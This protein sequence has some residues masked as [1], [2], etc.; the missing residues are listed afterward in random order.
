MTRHDYLDRALVDWIAEQDRHRAGY[1]DE[2]LSA[3]RATRQRP[4]WSFPG[5]WLP[6]ELTM[7]RVI[8]PRPV[9]YLI[10]LA[11]A[12]L[13][14]AIALVVGAMPRRVAPPFGLA[15]N[16]LVAYTTA[17]GDIATV[18]PVS[19]GTKV[20]VSS[21]ERESL[22]IFSRDGSRLAF[23]REVDG[24]VALFALDSR[25]G[26]PTRLTANPVDD[27]AQ[28]A[29]SPDGS[30]LAFVSD[31]RIWLVSTDK[32]SPEKPLDLG[33]AT[34]A[35]HPV[36][37]PS[38]AAQIVFRGH[39]DA[40]YSLMLADAGGSNTRRISEVIADDPNAYVFPVITPN[41]DRL[42]TQVDRGV[43]VFDLDPSSG[44]ATNPRFA[45]ALGA[46]S[47]TFS[48]RISP[49]GTRVAFALVV[50]DNALPRIAV[51]RLDDVSS[52][53]VTGP[54]LPNSSFGFDWS[55]DGTAILFWRTTTDQV[56]IL[57]P[58]GGPARPAPWNEAKDPNWQ[59]AAP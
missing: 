49:D 48:P 4:A 28:V 30:R 18:D 21:P 58:N 11:L 10:V 32:S 2:V 37:R 25:G 5:R 42:V 41:G 46:T 7:R 57:D 23:V 53:T 6:M 35:D 39:T 9:L 15:S 43:V 52:S 59:R 22:P 33:E 50:N 47:T 55:P 51:A 1:L 14:L 34:S 54:D 27:V 12:L 44:Q 40:G 38:T 20:L 26:T 3:T 13:A 36:W 56:L 45:D 17:D 19:S 29:W 16:G 8:V 31:S 24:G